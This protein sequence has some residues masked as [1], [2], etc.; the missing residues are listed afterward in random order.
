MSNRPFRKFDHE[1][2]IK[3]VQR[4]WV[5]C[6]WIDD[7]DHDKEVVSD[8]FRLGE[9]EV[10]T[11]DDEAECSVHWTEGKI[12]Y[13]NET[14][15][16]GA[17]TAVTTSHIARKLGFAKVLTARSL[18]RQH[19]VGKSVSALGIFEQGFY[20]KIGYGTGPY[21]NLVQFDPASLKVSYPFRPP[22]RLT[23]ADYKQMHGAL[24]NR[25][26]FHG[27]VDLHPA[28]S[29]RFELK[30]TDK[31]FGLG[32]Y[33]GPDGRLSHFIWG[34]RKGEY[35]PYDITIRAYQNREQLME[36]LTLVKS[37]ADQVSS[38]STLEFG[39]F[40]LQDLLNQPF[41]TRRSTKGG[42][43]AQLLEAVAFWQIRILD[44]EACLAKTHLPGP[45]VRFNLE[46]T[47][48]VYEILKGET[49]WQ[50]ISGDYVIDLGEESSARPGSESGLPRLKASVNA[51]S[52]LWFGVRPATNLAITDE[53]YGDAQLLER[54]DAAVRLP[55]PHFGWDF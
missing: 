25:R 9:T 26:K 55:K 6:G 27:A 20:D 21:E 16:L 3:S 30:S 34:E 23:D 18:A 32:Y 47:D 51:F 49:G 17:V 44:L 8:L 40:Q 2:D 29:V 28:E 52:R 19:E 4:I 54:L 7:E 43:Y 36:L 12:R 39:E 31:P 24:C 15:D 10:G 33:D 37:L 14:L 13:Q 5:E 45:G 38:I 50:G 41:R 46:L 48:P 11:I 22:K 53:L 35:G 1:R 42:N